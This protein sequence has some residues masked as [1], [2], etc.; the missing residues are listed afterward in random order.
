MNGLGIGQQ[1]LLSEIIRLV[2]SIAG[3]ADC[4]VLSPTANVTVS[5][6]QIARMNASNVQVV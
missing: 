5:D 3:V 6:G 2:K 4:A 1:V